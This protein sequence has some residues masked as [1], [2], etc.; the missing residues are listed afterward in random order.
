MEHTNK[1]KFEK[2]EVVQFIENHKWCGCLGIVGEIKNCDND[3]RYL[4]G[5]PIPQKGTAYIFSMESA[6]EFERIGTAVMVEG[7]EEE[8][9]E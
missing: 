5:V 8:D 6:H 1:P 9:D 3:Y 7:E 2:N 4:V